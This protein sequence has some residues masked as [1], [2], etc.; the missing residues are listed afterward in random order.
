M[1]QN[2]RAVPEGY[3][4]LSPLLVVR[5]ADQAIEFYKKAFGAEVRGIGR[6][7]GNKV[8]H[9]A[10]KIGDSTLMLSD[11][12]PEWHSL[13]PQSFGGTGT[14]IHI[15]VENAD[16]FFA[17]AI[18]AGATAAMPMMDAFWGDRYGKLTDP[19]GHA[20]SVATHVKDLTP[21]EMESAI[22]E[23]CAGMAKQ[24]GQ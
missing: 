1:A 18:A 17:R 6:G 9:A 24:A 15:Y 23:A 2:V 22:K 5:G 11:E 19:F 16:A 10:L 4:T 3:N 13:G 14:T 12:F 21:A 8:I 20:W 7:P